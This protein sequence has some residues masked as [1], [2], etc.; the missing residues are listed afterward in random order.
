MPNSNNIA[1]YLSGG[2]ARGAYQAGVLKGINE[3]LDNQTIPFKTISSVSAGSVNA[4]FLAQHADNFENATTNI[5]NVW[6]KLHCH[7][8]F[9]ASNF[10]LSKSVIRN[11]SNLFIRNTQSG[12]LLD[13]SPLRNLLNTYVNFNLITENMKNNHLSELEI[14]AYS[15]NTQQTVSFIHTHKGN[16]CEWHYPKHVTNYHDIKADHILASTALPLFFPTIKINSLHYGDGSLGLLTPLRGCIRFNVDK[17]LIIGTSSMVPQHKMQFHHNDE[18]GFAPVLGSMLNAFFIDN[19]DKDI[20]MVNRM[21]EIAKMVSVWNKNRTSWRPI[22]TLYIRPSCNIAEIAQKHYDSMPSFL[23]FLLN[24]LGAKQHSGN[25]LSFL[26]FEESFTKP[27][28]ELGYNDAMKQ[29]HEIL[30]FFSQ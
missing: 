14:I 21:N 25:L 3:L 20:E 5:C 8:V 9:T 12:Y 30:H 15:Y 6:S 28:I 22:Q 19:L 2:G 27:L 10:D 16:K 4:A 11:I 26:L 23:R 1:L 17:I 13:S 29:K 18:M 7:D 24:V